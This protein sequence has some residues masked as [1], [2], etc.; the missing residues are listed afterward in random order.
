MMRSISGLGTGN[1]PFLAFHDGFATLAT[2]VSSGGWN[3][4]LNGW[5][6]VAMD[7]HRYL[8]FDEPNNYGLAYQA[9]LVR[10]S[11]KSPSFPPPLRSVRGK[12]L[13]EIAEPFRAALQLLG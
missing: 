6:R 5:D 1:G 4:F 8:C 12:R 2:N 13:I 10:F 11:S 3:G 9:S 7:S